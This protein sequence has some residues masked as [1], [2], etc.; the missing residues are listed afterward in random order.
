MVFFVASTIFMIG[1]VVLDSASQSTGWNTFILSG[2]NI[3]FWRLS[4]NK[5]PSRTNLDRQSIE[6]HSV[7]CP[8][9]DVDV[10]TV[11]H[12]FFTC[13]VASDLWN[14]LGSWWDLDFPLY[15]SISEWI[16][17]I[18]FVRL[19]R[20]VKRCLEATVLTMF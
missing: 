8:L 6:V 4:L 20:N 11:N 18:D 5:I 10:E 12:L 3:L 13:G 19:S 14:L 2:V 17:W 1:F 15:L 16:T 9:C 7:L